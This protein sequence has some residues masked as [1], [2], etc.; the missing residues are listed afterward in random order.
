MMKDGV[1]RARNSW[2]WS[3]QHRLTP[4]H[5]DGRFARRVFRK[6]CL[7]D[8]GGWRDRWCRDIGNSGARERHS[9]A[10]YTTLLFTLEPEEILH[11]QTTLFPFLLSFRVS[12]FSP[13]PSFLH[14]LSTLKAEPDLL[15]LSPL[16]FISHLS[17]SW[18]SEGGIARAAVL[19]YHL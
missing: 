13:L 19:H 3:R 2:S 5:L 9:N 12:I 7:A 17:G 8:S 18:V 1:A 6:K 4:T 14:F 11:F 16:S 10:E 15:F